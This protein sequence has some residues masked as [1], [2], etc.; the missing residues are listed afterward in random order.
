M[1]RLPRQDPA[2]LPPAV[3]AGLGPTPLNAGL[4]MAGASEAVF[5]AAMGLLTVFLH[6][7]SLSPELREIGILRTAHRLGCAYIVHQHSGLARHFGLGEDYLAAIWA[8]DAEALGKVGGAVLAFVDDQIDHV[9]A[10]DSALAAV[11]V[12]LTD[13]QVADLVLLIGTYMMA[14]RLFE[15]AGVEIDDRPTDWNLYAPPI[16]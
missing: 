14:S 13:R 7:C 11:R 10:S 1:S 8:G 3:R 4:T 6:N 9:R 16:P 2:T 5:Q 15:T 12:H